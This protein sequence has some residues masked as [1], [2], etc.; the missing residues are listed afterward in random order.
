MA[1]L[2][3]D[4]YLYYSCILVDVLLENSDGLR[5]SVLAELKDLK[6]VYCKNIKN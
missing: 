3:N 1:N 4:D 2:E 5:D 6:K